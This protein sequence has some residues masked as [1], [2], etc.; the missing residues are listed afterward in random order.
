MELALATKGTGVVTSVLF[1]SPDDHATVKDLAKKTDYYKIKKG[2]AE[3]EITPIRTPSYRELTAEFL[4]KMKIN[5]PKDAKPLAEAKE[6]AY[7]E[8]FYQG[9]IF[10]GDFKGGKVGRVKPQFVRSYWW[11]WLCRCRCGYVLLLGWG[12]LHYHTV[13]G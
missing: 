7:K 1:D 9:T 4:V 8:G 2:W 6:L 5:S 13:V 11:G 12:L 10:I 3:L